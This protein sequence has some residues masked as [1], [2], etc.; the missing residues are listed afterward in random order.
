MIADPMALLACPFGQRA[1]LGILQLRADHEEGRLDIPGR[2]D[3]EHGRRDVRF[4]TVVE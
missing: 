4:R 2:K 3:I 1:T